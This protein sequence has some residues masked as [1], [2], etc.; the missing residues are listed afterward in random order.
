MI[1]IEVAGY[2]KYVYQVRGHREPIN[3]DYLPT[4]S[5]VR[6][7]GEFIKTWVSVFL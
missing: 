2:L 1:S 3:Y 4:H 7:I 6:G 5:I